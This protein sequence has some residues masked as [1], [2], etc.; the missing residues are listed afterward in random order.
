MMRT[1]AGSTARKLLTC[2]LLRATNILR[3]SR[4]AGVTVFGAISGVQ[5]SVCHARQVAVSACHLEQFRSMQV[6]R[7]QG[8]P[9]TVDEMHHMAVP[10]QCP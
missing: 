10:A 4:G 6:S 8:T 3:V 5:E 1:I 7:T 9:V 2:W